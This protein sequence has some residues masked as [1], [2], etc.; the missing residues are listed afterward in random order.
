[1]RNIISTALL[2]FAAAPIFA[3]VPDAPEAKPTPA[4]A[5]AET[6]VSIDVRDARFSD[7]ILALAKQGHFSFVADAYLGD[8]P[9]KRVQIEA[10]PLDMAIQKVA[11]L[12]ERKISKVN[13]VY[14]LSH[15]RRVLAIGQDEF[16]RTQY[17][18]I[19]A[20]AGELTV[21]PI[22]TLQTGPTTIEIKPGMILP[23]FASVEA[24]AVS[25]FRFAEKLSD[26]T[27]GAI[28]IKKDLAERRLSAYFE[29]TTPGEAAEAV[30]TLFHARQRI[31]IE[32]SDAQ[33]KQ[34]ATTLTDMNDQ[35]DPLA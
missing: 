26:A 32:Q 1:M 13:G 35:R 14:I 25:A 2:L 10:V 29:R 27:D 5:A 19:W 30:A 33:V 34:D 3:Q 11:E 20:T 8:F 28:Y 17:A 15:S 21:K 22:T 24:N 16:R 4:L 9:V 23:P 12:F 18:S 6:R 31:T 7:A